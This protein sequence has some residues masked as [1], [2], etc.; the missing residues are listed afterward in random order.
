MTA[1]YLFRLSEPGFIHGF[2]NILENVVEVL[3]EIVNLVRTAVDQL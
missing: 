2:V 1:I 3:A